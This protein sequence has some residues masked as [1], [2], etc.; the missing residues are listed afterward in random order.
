[1][2]E[3]LALEFE[4]PGGELVR[5]EWHADRL[6]S[7]DPAADGAEPVWRLGGELDW[8]EIEAVRVLSA[9]LDDGRLIAIVALRPSA[10]PGHGEE[11]VAGALGDAEAF[12][13]L[14]EALI[15]T[16]FGADGM[17]TRVGLELYPSPDAIPLRVAADVTATADTL[18]GG[19]RRISA[20]LA[21]RAAGDGGSGALDTLTRA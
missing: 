2:T 3:A 1:M 20:A 10:A 9:H 7:F 12:A 15:S 17:P 5:F 18:E 11:I 19:L 6:A 4:A 16:E 14:D 8:D 13:Q 21:V